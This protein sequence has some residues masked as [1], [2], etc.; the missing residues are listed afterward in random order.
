MSMVDRS[1]QQ[2]FYGLVA[3]GAFA[4]FPTVKTQV[5]STLIFRTRDE[6]EDYI[7]EFLQLCC[8]EERLDNLDSISTQVYVVEYYLFEKQAS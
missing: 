8:N 3:K 7:L 6:A 4:S 2:K 5:S 1:S